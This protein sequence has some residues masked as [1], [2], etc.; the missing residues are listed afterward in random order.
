LQF[1]D[2]IGY[3]EVK[4]KLGKV[5]G[6]AKPESRNALRHFGISSS[7]GGVLLYGPP[8]NSKTRLVM[9]A[10]STYS[11]PV[12]SLSVAD[13]Y[14]AYVGNAEAEIRRAFR[15]ARQAHPCV[16]F[17][18]ELDAL[19]TDRGTGCSSSSNV[20]SRVLAS[21][22]TEMDGIDGAA[23]DVFV[24]AA[25]NRLESIDA[26]LLRKGRFH[27]ILHV[28]LP[29]ME[30]RHDMVNYFGDKYSLSETVR[31]KISH[32]L[33]DLM[34]GADVENL[35]REEGMNRIKSFI[36]GNTGDV[37]VDVSPTVDSLI[38]SP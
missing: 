15:L 26:A 7:M 16:L 38:G 24:V 18:D 37:S 29:T 23:D 31:K 17:L 35:C 2:I 11:L 20:E 19:V 22:L 32:K 30:A 33:T 10:A 36:I 12:I 13:V 28:S 6:F 9:A 14:S 8:G 3:D 34:S 1:E 5:L 25:T 27:H 4:V 21:L